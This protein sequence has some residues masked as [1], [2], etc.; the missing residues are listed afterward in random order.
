MVVDFG[1]SE[2]FKGKIFE[3]AEGIVNV[4]AAVTDFV[5]ERFEAE[6]IHGF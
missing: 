5:K 4:D 3:A 6:G 2:V 1:E